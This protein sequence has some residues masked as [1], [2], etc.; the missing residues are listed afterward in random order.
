MT[1]VSE[2][3]SGTFGKVREF[4]RDVVAEFRKVNWPSRKQVTGSTT[5]VIVVVLALAVFLW[6]VDQALS[7]AVHQI[8]R[9]VGFRS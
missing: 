9:L 2:L 3:F 4:F 7:A 1:Q 5:V 6:M 8:F